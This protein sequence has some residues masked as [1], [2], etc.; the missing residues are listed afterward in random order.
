MDGLPHAWAALPPIPFGVNPALTGYCKYAQFQA[1]MLPF[2]TALG[3]AL[4]ALATNPALALVVTTP[5]LLATASAA[6]LAALPL[7]PLTETKTSYINE[8][9]I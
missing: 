2:L 1:M 3:P 4:A 5:P 6:A 9:P 8:L 7:M